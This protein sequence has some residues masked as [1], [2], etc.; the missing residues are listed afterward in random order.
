MRRFPKEIFVKW[1]D[2]GGSED[3]PFLTA[4]EDAESASD[5]NETVKAGLYRLVGLR[6]IV[7][8]TRVE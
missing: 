4:F 5:Q 6:S 8:G 3:E 1:E 2:S 7:N